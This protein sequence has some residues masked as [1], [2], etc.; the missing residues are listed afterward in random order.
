[1][2]VEGSNDSWWGTCHCDVIVYDMFGLCILGNI[3]ELDPL[4]ASVSMD[5]SIVSDTFEL[6][7]MFSFAFYYFI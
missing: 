2:L 7:S 5:C 1:M 4:S 6:F 3:I